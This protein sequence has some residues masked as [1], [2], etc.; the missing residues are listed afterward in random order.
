MGFEKDPGYYKAALKR[1]E[2]E[3]A[4]QEIFE[5][6]TGHYMRHEHEQMRMELDATVE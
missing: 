3:T 5:E 4:Q 1:I 2:R 6:M